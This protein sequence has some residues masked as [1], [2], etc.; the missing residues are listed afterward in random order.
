MRLNFYLNWQALKKPH[1][2]CGIIYILNSIRKNIKVNNCDTRVQY[3]IGKICCSANPKIA[4]IPQVI[5]FIKGKIRYLNYVTSTRRIC[6]LG[7]KTDT[8][9]K[10]V[11]PS[12][13]I[14]HIITR[15]GVYRVVSRSSQNR[16]AA[17]TPIDYII[18]ASTIDIITIE[19]PK[20]CIVICSTIYFISE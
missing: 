15:T 4:T 20:D 1:C 7:G 6:Y 10:N 12:S 18:F 19:V 5:Y 14:N 9:Q 2:P 11:N 13:T 8:E 16:I 3:S 17:T